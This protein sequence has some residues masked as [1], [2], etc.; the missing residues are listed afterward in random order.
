VVT[1]FTGFIILA[2]VF[3]SLNCTCG[4]SGRKLLLIHVSSEC[5]LICVG[6]RR[7]SMF[8][9]YCWQHTEQLNYVW[10]CLRIMLNWTLKK[11]CLWIRGM[12]VIWSIYNIDITVLYTIFGRKRWISWPADLVVKYCYPNKSVRTACLCSVMQHSWHNGV[13]KII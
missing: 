6:L 8:H 7:R 11:Q 12:K 10:I 2:A 5:K 3:N 4:V 13:P 1:N 9:I